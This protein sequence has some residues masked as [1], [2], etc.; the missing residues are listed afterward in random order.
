MYQAVEHEIGNNEE[1]LVL[2]VRVVVC[3]TDMF[4]NDVRKHVLAN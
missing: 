2:F 1:V 3:E 4:P